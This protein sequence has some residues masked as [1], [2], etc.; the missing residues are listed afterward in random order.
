MMFKA[1]S[2]LSWVYLA[3]RCFAV[4]PAAVYDGDG[5][6][7]DAEIALKIGN[8]GAGQSGLVGGRYI[9]TGCS[10]LFLTSAAL[11]NAFV[12]ESVKDNGTA[13]FRVGKPSTLFC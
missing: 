6:A 3:V 11:S 10:T 7:K 2:L 5:V 13:P 12:K 4:D 9:Q 1:P 8:G